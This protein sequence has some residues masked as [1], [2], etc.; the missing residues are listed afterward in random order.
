MNSVKLVWL[1]FLL[2]FLS[3]SSSFDDFDNKLNSVCKYMT[4]KFLVIVVY[5]NLIAD[6]SKC[7]LFSTIFYSFFKESKNIGESPLSCKVTRQTHLDDSDHYRRRVLYKYCRDHSDG[8]WERS[9]NQN[10]L[11]KVTQITFITHHTAV[12]GTCQI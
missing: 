8:Y 7:L 9:I 6:H 10:P 1:P 11:D 5:S 4:Y 3:F 12:D 2:F